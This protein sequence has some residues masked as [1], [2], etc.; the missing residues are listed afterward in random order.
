MN[1]QKKISACIIILILF[2]S[3]ELNSQTRIAVLYSEFS[4]T[5]FYTNTNNYLD[6]FTAWE[7]FLMQNKIKYKVIY[8][9]DLDSGLE[10]DFEIL[11][12]PRYNV[13]SNEKYSAIKSFLNAGKSIISANAFNST[14]VNSN[15]NELK[16]LFGITLKNEI[17][18]HKLNFTQ[19]ISRSPINSFKNQSGFL[20]SVNNN[21]FVDLKTFN[22]SSAGYVL[23]GDEKSKISSIVYGYNN[24][25][26]FVFTGFGL[27]DLIG[28]SQEYKNFELFLIDALKWL[29]TEIDAFPYL[30]INKKEK[31]KLLLVQYNNAFNKNFAEVLKQN[32][33][34]PHI[35]VN[36]TLQPDKILFNNISKDQIILDLR[37]ANQDNKTSESIVEFIKSFELLNDITVKSVF[38]SSHFTASQITQ[39]K[40]YGINN[41][42]LFDEKISDAQL[43]NDESFF[44]FINQ[45]EKSS[46]NNLMEIIYFV[47]K[48]DCEKDIENDFLADLKNKAN[49]QTVFTDITSL[50]NKILLERKLIIS[51]QNS[52]NVEISVRNDNAVEIKD[53]ILYVNIKDFNIVTDKR[54]S[55]LNYTVDPKSGMK[56]IYINKILPGS[57]EKIIFSSGR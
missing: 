16:D 39:L 5:T 9:E 22:Y 6:E 44:L 10:D 34:N 1:I 24:S 12:L 32:N 21:Q 40:E 17:L 36:E 49:D 27:T 18:N 41:F 14:M 37:S 26:K 48:I 11:I 51:I 2:T 53:L 42:V 3:A 54:K 43:N 46:A 8:D 13:Q 45:S 15:V 57:E 52:Q 29:D 31:L 38:I 4:Q 56:L 7:I 47:P 19:T 23:N 55:V 28:G 20:V 30:T 25:G 35:V 33:F 50:K